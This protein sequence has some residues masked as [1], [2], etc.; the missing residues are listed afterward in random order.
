MAKADYVNPDEM[1]F[2]T[3]LKLFKHAIGDYA[4]VLDVSSGEVTQQAADTDFY[5]YVV[6]CYGMLNSSG[7]SATIF[8]NNLRFAKEPGPAASLPVPV[9][10][11]APPAVPPGVE[12]RFRQLVRR[13][14][15]HPKYE[16][17]IGKHLGIE[18]SEPTKTAAHELQPTFTLELRAAGVFIRWGWDN[19]REQ[20]D[21]CELVVDRHDGQGERLV[22]IDATPGYLD[23]EPF[24]AAPVKWTYRAIYHKGDTRIGQWSVPVSIVVGG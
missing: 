19:Q 12:K 20:V 18:G 14:K 5:E 4:P 23:P 15:R 16:L 17:H 9:F 1:G 11:P 8:R 13:I 24:P 21:M 2:V 22:T 6:N 7:K 3:Q 10:P